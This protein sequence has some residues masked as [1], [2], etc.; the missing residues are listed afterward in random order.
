[1]KLKFIHIGVD[2]T[3][4]F[5]IAVHIITPSR[6]VNILTKFLQR[7]FSLMGNIL[8]F[9]LEQPGKYKR[10]ILLGTGN[11]KLS[12]M[13][14]SYENNLVVESKI[15][16]ACRVLLNRVELIQLQYLK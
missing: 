3:D 13:M 15:H 16:D 7:I 9:I 8:S 2:P 6:Y 4:M 12:S 10:T 14:Y 5:R 11:L 1:V